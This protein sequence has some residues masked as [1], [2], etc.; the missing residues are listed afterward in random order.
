MICFKDVSFAYEKGK[1]VL[2][3]INFNVEKGEKVGLIGSN[4]AGKSTLM[5]ASL[6]LV[7]TQGEIIIGELSVEKK[8]LPG[9]RKILGYVLQESD[10]QMFMPT[11]LE[12]MEFGLL[13]MKM[14]KAEAY[15]RCLE[16]LKE[17][18]LEYLSDKYNHKI[19]GGEKRM[20]AIATILA[21]KPEILLMD[22][23]T[24]SLDPKNRRRIINTVK[25]LSHTMIIATH[26]L[27]MVLETCDRVLLLN[28]GRIVEDGDAKKILSDKELLEKNGLELPLC[29]AVRE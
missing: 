18:E 26:D 9:I 5:K 24:S 21:M 10:N 27:D 4:G 15:E 20:A 2:N 16:V 17:L 23:P 14:T 8:N 13:N 22:E 6:G 12:D 29:L 3:S 19:S 28:E 7:E 1:N 25:S 11:V